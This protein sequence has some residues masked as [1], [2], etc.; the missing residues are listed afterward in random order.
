MTSFLPVSVHGITFQNIER[1]AEPLRTEDRALQHMG[2]LLA[3]LEHIGDGMILLNPHLRVVHMTGSASRLLKTCKDHISVQN[4]QLIL[5]DPGKARHLREFAKKAFSSDVDCVGGAF[6]IFFIE[7]LPEEPLI[8][9]VFALS[10]IQDPSMER[11]LLLVL[12]D[13]CHR[14]EPNW[15]CFAE[16]FGL[17][18][19]EL[20]LCIALTND[21]SI[22]EYSKKFHISLHTARSQLKRI[23]EKT[24]T[25]RQAQLLRLIYA[26]VHS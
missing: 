20:R 9:S 14:C 16:R 1:R 8:A 21:S 22:A 11:Q 7:R 17:T 13:P 10:P 19:A 23:F 15:I 26:F 12:R 2:S 24:A 18:N 5:A 3:C 25:H 4:H 6:F